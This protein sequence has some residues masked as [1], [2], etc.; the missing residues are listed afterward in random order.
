[1]AHSKQVGS[2]HLRQGSNFELCKRWSQ[3]LSQSGSAR[4]S[5]PLEIITADSLADSPADLWYMF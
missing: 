3:Q 4:E 2:T 5:E 1:M